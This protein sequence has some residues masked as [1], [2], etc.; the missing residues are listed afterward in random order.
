MQ[1]LRRAIGV[2]C[3]A[4]SASR[5]PASR[6]QNSSTAQLIFNVSQLISYMSHMFVLLPGDI[7]ATNGEQRLGEARLLPLAFF[8]LPLSIPRYQ[9]FVRHNFL[10]AVRR[11]QRGGR[12]P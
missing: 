8:Y 11:C 9:A 2:A 12:R 5:N 3:R 7:I 10:C 4:C 1:A 6:Y